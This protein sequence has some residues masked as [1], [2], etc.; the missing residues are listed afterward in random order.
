MA[1]NQEQIL[2]LNQKLD[3]LISQQEDFLV[4]VDVLRTEIEKLSESSVKKVSTD[5]INPSSQDAPTTTIS[6]SLADEEWPYLVG[7]EGIKAEVESFENGKTSGGAHFIKFTIYRNSKNYQAFC[8]ENGNWLLN[9]TEGKLISRGRFKD[10]GRIINVTLGHLKGQQFQNSTIIENI[11]QAAELNS[12]N[13]TVIEDVAEIDISNKPITPKGKSNIERYIGENL[14]TIIGVVIVLIG[15]VFGVKYSIDH[16]LISPLTRVLL[17]YLL[18]IGILLV[19]MKLRKKYEQYSA[20]LVSGA[21]AIMYFVT[22]TAYSLYGL[23]PQLATFA[24]MVLFTMFTVVTAISYN[25]QIIAHIGLVGSYAVPFLLSNGDGNITSLFT[26]MAIVNGGILVIA[27][28]KHW[29]PLYY[30]A[31][32]CTWAIYFLW[33]ANEYSN[34]SHFT[35]A[36]TFAI[37]FF[38]MFY[39]TFLVYK[40]IKKEKFAQEDV[41]MIILN[42]AIFYGLSFVILDQN[43]FGRD[44]IG[45]FTVGTAIVHFIVSIILFKTKLA[46]RNLFYLSS[47]MVLVFIT[48]AVPVQLDGN[49]VTLLWATE[50]AL[51]FWIGRTKGV[52]FYEKLS[53]VVMG[54]ALF[55]LLEDYNYAY[56][57]SYYGR[58]RTTLSAFKNAMFMT[59]AIV[60]ACY[61]FILYINTREKYSAKLRTSYSEGLRLF[62][63]ALTIVVIGLVYN[64]FRIEFDL[65]GNYLYKISETRV[66]YDTSYGIDVSIY[67][68]RDILNFK[69]LWIL[70]YTL[71]FVT[72]LVYLNLKKIK[73][74]AFGVT[75]LV[76][77]SLMVLSFLVIGLYTL[78][79]LRDSYIRQPNSEVFSY[80]FYNIGMRYIGYVFV[81][82]SMYSIF[83]SLKNQF[84]NNKEL[85]RAFD[86]LKHGV[87]L[88]L[89]CSEL[90]NIMG[91]NGSHGNYKLE[92]SILV[93]LYAILLVSLG[94]W[95][96][97]QYLRIAA[98][99]IFGATL[100]KLF[101][102]D[103]AR[104][105]TIAK[106]VVFI[107]LGVLLLVISFLY[108]K[109]KHLIIDEEE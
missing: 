69:T 7:L 51:L 18:G 47:G 32:G 17:S 52:R 33:F 68:D 55:S 87:F 85:N 71:L 9:N 82:G 99:S 106:T 24:I 8:A 91:L 30:V 60:S 101:L 81:A 62:T 59:T 95:K 26:Y 72:G 11:T 1:S 74:N 20:V 105:T 109:Y 77:N 93:G 100:L 19:G 41:L 6:N 83:R 10:D 28:K 44:Y 38:L 16:N 70:N 92:L 21:M 48:I 64:M 39:C 3:I 42:S 86:L 40:L 13:P 56:N 58:S 65:Y 37:V 50:G 27:Y 15:V 97:K 31:F 57:F 75:T 98:I 36:L 53:Y 79:E 63:A 84:E 66:P 76:I 46:D 4:E 22:F 43:Q 90:I 25:R 45:L 88:W 80:S 89:L 14:I 102:Y 107:S 29:K 94:I 96:R 35:L 104:S 54:I 61:G 2:A 12:L 49:W 78:S 103:M 67:Y 5:R 23:F 34:N 108:N 73:N